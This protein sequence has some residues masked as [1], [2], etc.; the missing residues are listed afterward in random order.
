MAKGATMLQSVIYLDISQFHEEQQY[1]YQ[2]LFLGT[3]FFY[4]GL[5]TENISS[6]KKRKYFY[7]ITQAAR[8]CGL[9]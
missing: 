9:H 6:L 5:T 1:M 8:F 7:I 3:F 2:C 4:T